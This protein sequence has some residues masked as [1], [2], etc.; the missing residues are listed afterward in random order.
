M[1][2]PSWICRILHLFKFCLY[3]LPVIC[4]YCKYFFQVC[5]LSV[6]THSFVFSHLTADVLSLHSFHIADLPSGVAFFCLRHVFKNSLERIKTT[7]T[8]SVWK[9]I[10]FIVYFQNILILEKYFC[11]VCS[12]RLALSLACK[13][14]LRLCRVVGQSALSSEGLPSLASFQISF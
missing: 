6:W 3:Y 4:I 2:C 10:Y 13:A 5:Y 7:F 12:P 9:Y 1:F 11:W 8:L 14:I